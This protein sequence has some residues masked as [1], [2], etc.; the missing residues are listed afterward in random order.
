METAST[1]TRRTYAAAGVDVVDQ[2]LSHRSTPLQI[3]ARSVRGGRITELEIETRAPTTARRTVNAVALFV[4]VLCIGL[5]C[6][7]LAPLALGYR[8][9][10]VVSGSMAPTL[11]VADIVVVDDPE[12]TSVV[13]GT[14]IDY[15]TP[16]GHEIHRVVEILP[17]SFRTKGDA[18]RTADS[19]LVARDSVSGVGVF[20]VPFI[21]L[22]YVWLENG[23]WLKLGA[24]MTL[25]LAAG[26]FSRSAWL[27]PPR[28][29]SGSWRSMFRLGG[30]P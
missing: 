18:N 19:D 9:V 11:N 15:E 5:F 2:T 14:V 22:P 16:D 12:D 8:Q 26:Y 3:R 25:F 27:R 21:G 28:R 1:L 24:L 6:L 30:S 13:L 23:D 4:F 7:A 29:R 17:D 20:L 10:V